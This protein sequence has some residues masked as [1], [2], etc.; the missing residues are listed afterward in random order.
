MRASRLFSAVLV[1]LVVLV[2]ANAFAADRVALICIYNDT[3]GTI[4]F[5][6]RWNNSDWVSTSVRP[7]HRRSVWWNFH[8]INDPTPNLDVTFD[9]D[10]TDGLWW[11]TYNLDPQRA[12]EATCDH[13]GNVYTFEYDSV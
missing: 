8:Y 6:Y 2:T 4:N 9:S 7:G 10:M 12:P 5:Q 3:N 11:I 1:T 13:Y